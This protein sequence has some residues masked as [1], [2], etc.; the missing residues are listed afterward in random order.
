MMLKTGNRKLL[1]A[2]GAGI[3]SVTS[4]ALGCQTTTVPSEAPIHCVTKSESFL[5]EAVVREKMRV[6]E[7][8]MFGEATQ[9]HHLA[10]RLDYLEAYCSSINSYRGED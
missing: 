5:Y 8:T 4:S 7:P 9:Y 6:F 1:G 3:F 2:I 10:A